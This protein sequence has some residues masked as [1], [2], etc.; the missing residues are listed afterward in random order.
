MSA[1]MLVDALCGMTDEQRG[2]ITEKLCSDI[3]DMVKSVNDHLPYM[4]TKAMAKETESV[5]RMVIGKKG[6]GQ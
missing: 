5:C 1:N 6:G 2:E 3:E 4:V